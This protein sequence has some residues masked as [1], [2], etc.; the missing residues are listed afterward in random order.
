MTSSG[1]VAENQFNIDLT[2]NKIESLG[3]KNCGARN[4]QYSGSRTSGSK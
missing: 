2:G 1:V 4:E 3:K